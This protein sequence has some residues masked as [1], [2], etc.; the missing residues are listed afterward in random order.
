MTCYGLRSRHTFFRRDKAA[1]R[2]CTH[3]ISLYVSVRIKTMGKTHGFAELFLV[4]VVVV[5]SSIAGPDD[6]YL[7]NGG[8]KGIVI[9]IEDNVEYDPNI[10]PN[11]KVRV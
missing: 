8:Y 7:E 3:G 11:L 1:S 6:I 4:L 5:G 9:A 2:Y 10:I